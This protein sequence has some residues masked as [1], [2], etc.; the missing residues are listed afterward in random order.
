MLFGRWVLMRVHKHRRSL[1]DGTHRTTGLEE[2]AFTEP[3]P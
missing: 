3:V 2:L 1:T